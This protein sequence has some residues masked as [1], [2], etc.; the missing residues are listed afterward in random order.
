MNDI[1][2]NDNTRDS[3]PNSYASCMHTK[4]Q[5]LSFQS[6]IWTHMDRLNITCVAF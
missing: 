1:A 5:F 4:P 2:W 3:L 6:P